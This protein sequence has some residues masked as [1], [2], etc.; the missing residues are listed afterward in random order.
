LNF[1]SGREDKLP[2]DQNLLGALIA[3]RA[4][5]YH[6]SIA[7][8]GLNAWANEQNYYSVKTVYDF[9]KVPDR[10]AVLT[11]MGEHAVAARDVEKTIDFLDI[12]FGRRDL[13]WNN[14]LFYPYDYKAWEKAHP[15]EREESRH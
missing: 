3:P 1:F 4:L 6:Y 2:V 13:T 10:V 9:L 11:R 12:Q 15:T 5:L 14:Q 8:R 7:E